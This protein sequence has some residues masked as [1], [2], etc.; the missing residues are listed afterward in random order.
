MRLSYNGIITAFQAEDTGSIPVGRSNAQVSLS[1]T[2]GA[3]GNW[4]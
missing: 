2:N 1:A 4:K 3:K